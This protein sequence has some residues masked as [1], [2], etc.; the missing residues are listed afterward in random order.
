MQDEF[1]P[2]FS[3]DG[4]SIRDGARVPGKLHL[5]GTG[6]RAESG[7]EI[8]WRGVRL[9]RD[10]ADGALLVIGKTVTIG[11]ADPG[12]Q[13]VLE[14]AAGNDL[15]RE[16]ARLEGLKTGWRGSS[17][18][19]C[20]VFFALMT[21]G[22]LSA[23]GCYYASVEKAVDRLPFS[24]DQQLGEAAEG[25]MDVGKEVDDEVVVA[26]I[27][28][29]VD[30]LAPEFEGTDL[31]EIL[32]EIDW[33]VRVVESD[34]PNAF[35]LPGGYITVFTALIDEA[36]SVDMVAGVIA[37]EMAH[38][39]QRHGLK[40]VGNKIGV[41]AGIQLIFG[42]GGGSLVGL[43]AEVL[44]SASL[45]DK[46][47]SQETESDLLGTDAMI[48]AGLEA[49]ALA[50]FF[51]DLERKYPDMTAGPEWLSTHPFPGP[52]AAAIRARIE[53]EETVPRRDLDLDWDDVRSRVAD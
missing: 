43:A 14:S 37:H 6:I 31:D 52:R 50:E 53:A 38:V 39:L 3:V 9:R 17:V 44:S 42:G 27:Q 11:S 29:I 1:D 8:P 19:G 35:A 34:T 18:M 22:I 15:D 48:R 20:I 16:L 49:D 51:L 41:M 30:R 7:P 32:L 26:A 46:D 13:R 4:F 45:Y 2:T 25:S 5:M 12:F 21:A 28:E 24:V 47:R 10:E 23:P 36:E 40:R 33:Q